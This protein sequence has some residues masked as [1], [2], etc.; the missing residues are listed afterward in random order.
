MRVFNETYHLK[1]TLERERETVKENRKRDDANEKFY[2]TSHGAA[3][4]GTATCGRYRRVLLV[5]QVDSTHS[6]KTA[7]EAVNSRNVAVFGK[8]VRAL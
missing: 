5:Y 8:S 6:S 7:Y 4:C 3:S 2:E 1:F